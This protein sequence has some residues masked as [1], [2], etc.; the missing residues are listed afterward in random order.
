MILLP[1]VPAHPQRWKTR[2]CALKCVCSYGSKQGRERK[3]KRNKVRTIWC[4]KWTYEKSPNHHLCKN[5]RGFCTHCWSQIKREVFSL[6][7]G[8]PDLMAILTFYIPLPMMSC[9]AEKTNKHFT[10]PI[11]KNKFWPMM[12][13]ERLKY[14]SFPSIEDYFIKSFVSKKVSKEYTDKIVREKYYRSVMGS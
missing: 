3:Q 13:K 12:L 14:F 11:V 1:P 7:N 6:I 10:L 4:Q 9:E 5:P 8:F 2:V